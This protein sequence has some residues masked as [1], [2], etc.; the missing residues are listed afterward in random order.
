MNHLISLADA[1]TP[2]LELDLRRVTTNLKQLKT[3]FAPLDPTLYYAVKANNDQRL[4]A[5]VRDAGCGF[6]VASI[7]EVRQLQ[8]RGVSGSDMPFSAR[9]KIPSHIEEASAR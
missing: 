6:E 4:L 9:V 5:P 1:R 3:A 7:Y 2:R 8:E